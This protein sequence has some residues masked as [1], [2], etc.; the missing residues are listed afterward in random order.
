MAR[1]HRENLLLDD[2]NS[3]VTGAGSAIARVR[4]PHD[5]SRLGPGEQL[6]GNPGGEL[7]DMGAP[8]YVLDPNRRAAP[9]PV[10]DVRPGAP[11]SI[12]RMLHADQ[13]AIHKAKEMERQL[14]AGLAIV[15]LDPS[16]VDPSFIVDRM[17]QNPEDYA[18][19]KNAIE[20]H[21]QDSPILVRPHPD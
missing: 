19:L 7:P 18:A 3:P 5:A 2:D 1:K 11:N 20:T 4:A 15:E 13:V 10:V 16:I 17:E 14:T 9:V 8:N 12:A 6:E 21:G